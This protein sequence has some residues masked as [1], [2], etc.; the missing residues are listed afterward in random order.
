MGELCPKN[1]IRKYS[2]NRLCTNGKLIYGT[3]SS[4]IGFCLKK[5]PRDMCIASIL[6]VEVEKQGGGLKTTHPPGESSYEKQLENRVNK[7]S[8]SNTLPEFKP[9]DKMSVY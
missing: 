6:S 7:S 2:T 3:V 4:K 9:D 5:W 8:S 1:E